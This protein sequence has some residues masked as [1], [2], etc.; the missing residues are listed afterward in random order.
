MVGLNE[1]WQTVESNIKINNHTQNKELG[2][3]IEKYSSQMVV[4]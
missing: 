1:F 3:L 2:T 4:L